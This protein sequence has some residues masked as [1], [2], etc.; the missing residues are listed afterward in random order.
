MKDRRYQV[1]VSSTYTDLQSERQG[2]LSALLELGCFPAGME[3]FPASD[4][5]P[6]A[7]I[8]RVI[9]DSDYYAVIVGGRYGSVTE[10]GLSFTQRE[11]EYA[12]RT[13]KPILAFLH[14]DPGSIPWRDSEQDPELHARLQ[15]FVTLLR[16]RHLVRTWT[17]VDSLRAVVATSLSA[18]M[19]N[20]PQMGWTRTTAGTSRRSTGF[21]VVRHKETLAMRPD[22]FDNHLVLDIRAVTSGLEV[23]FRHSAGAGSSRLHDIELLTPNMTLLRPFIVREPWSKAFVYLGRQLAQGETTT[24]SLREIYMQPGTWDDENVHGYYASHALQRLELEVTYPDELRPASAVWREYQ[25]NM[26]MEDVIAAGALDTSGNVLRYVNS[27]P[28]IGHNYVIE[29]NMATA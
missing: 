20:N 10:T 26:D 11:Y 25:G 22:G 16:S 1:F 14:A 12:Q 13:S 7:H 18:E 29:W 5:T 19:D 17:T 24:V 21:E 9:D 8:E 3:F 6:W 4:S 27:E 2:V 23:F 15:E 28:H